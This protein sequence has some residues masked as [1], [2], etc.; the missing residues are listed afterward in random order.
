[1]YKLDKNFTIAQSAKEAD[2]SNRFPPSASLGKRLEES[3]MLTAHAYG[4][5]PEDPPKME[6]FLFS[7]RKH[8]Q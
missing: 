3:W 4:I 7:F 1:M 2:K 6:K 8:S 5:D